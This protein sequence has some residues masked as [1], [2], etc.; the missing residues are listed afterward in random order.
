MILMLRDLPA[1]QAARINLLHVVTEQ[2]ASESQQHWT[3]AGSLLASAV[4]TLGLNP[5]DVNSI[6]RQGDTKQTVLS[7]AD[8]LDVVG[9]APGGEKPVCDA[10]VAQRGGGWSYARRTPG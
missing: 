7:V 9:G 4:E 10:I 5:K 2:S 6:I 8:E 1:F 3:R